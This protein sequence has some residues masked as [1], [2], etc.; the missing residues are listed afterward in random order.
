MRLEETIGSNSVGE[1]SQKCDRENRQ[2]RWRHIKSTVWW[3]LDLV[4]KRFHRPNCLNAIVPFSEIKSTRVLPS[5]Y[6]KMMNRRTLQACIL[7]HSIKNGM[8]SVLGKLNLFKSGRGAS[9][10]RPKLWLSAWELCTD[11]NARSDM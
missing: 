9:P 7:K 4:V 11:K 3:Y 2:W 5:F 8:F 10:P 1:C 6:I